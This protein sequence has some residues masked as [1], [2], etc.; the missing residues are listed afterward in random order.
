MAKN[1]I[2]EAVKE[3]G[4]LRKQLKIKAGKNIPEGTLEKAAEAKGKLWAR[5]RLAITLQ[6]MRDRRKN[7]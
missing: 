7:K 1:W 2:Q 5:A 6:K 4:G 3:K